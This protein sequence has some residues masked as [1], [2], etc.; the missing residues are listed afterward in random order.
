[1]NQAKKFGHKLSQAKGKVVAGAT[2]VYVAA[3]NAA[4]VDVPLNTQTDLETTVT[5]GGTVA[6]GITIAV[7]GTA[8][9]IGLLKKGK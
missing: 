9:I 1:M 3:A 6:I 5:N 8:I 7:L 2:G 4:P